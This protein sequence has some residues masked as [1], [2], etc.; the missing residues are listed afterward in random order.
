MRARAGIVSGRLR[1]TSGRERMLVAALTA[2]VLFYAP[3]LALE[4][5]DQAQTEYGEALAQRDAAQ[6]AQRQA[7]ALQTSA[8]RDLALEDMASWGFP[9]SNVEIVRVQ[10]ERAL[11]EAA[12]DAEL[13][14]LTIET[15]TATVQT[16]PIT[17][18]SARV[19][20]DLLWTPTFRFIDGVSRWPEGF[21]VTRFVFERPPPPAFEG[22]P[23]TSA[24]RVRLGLD[25]PARELG[26]TEARS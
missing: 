12:R 20:A 15:D 19:E 3:V 23:V 2:G 8:E 24:G 25:L 5:R 9:G 26:Q 6:R 21:R 22:A 11:T 10:V 13:T 4:A 18:V 1:R 17:W 7:I 16:G 14:G